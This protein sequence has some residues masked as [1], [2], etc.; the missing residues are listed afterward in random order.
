[1]TRKLTARSTL[2]AAVAI[3]TCSCAST[4]PLIAGSGTDAQASSHDGATD[5]HPVDDATTDAA[6][7]AM[8]DSFVADVVSPD[9]SSGRDGDP[10]SPSDAAAEAAC[11]ASSLTYVVDA[12]TGADTNAGSASAPLKTI[13]AAAHLATYCQTISVRSGTYDATNGEIFPITLA[14]GVLL[15]GD[16]PNKGNATAPVYVTGTCHVDGGVITAGLIEPGA[17]ATVAGLRVAST[18]PTT[19]GILVQADRVLVRNST[20]LP[21]GAQTLAVS[22]GR[23]VGSV[24]ES[25]VVQGNMNGFGF[26]SGGSMLRV[27][28][29]IVTGNQ[30]GI[31]VYDTTVVDL[32]GGDTHSAG[33]NVLSCNS[34]Q[35]LLMIGATV[36]ADGNQWDHAVPTLGCGGTGEDICNLAATSTVSVKNAT[37]APSNCP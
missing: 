12:V 19:A 9:A 22:V 23:S 34:Q 24:F 1:V 36:W 33:G 15:I 20:F 5:A 25:N 13:T 27:E 30:V 4:P 18:D 7:D 17:C 37:V 31:G 32:G 26:S 11:P 16:E 29:N 10:D 3:T 2:L 28:G 14:A 8:R 21:N 6:P 35:D